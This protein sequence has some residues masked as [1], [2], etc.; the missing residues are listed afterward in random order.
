[1]LY[2][3]RAG[4]PIRPFVGGGVGSVWWRGEAFCDWRQV[5]CQLVLPDDAPG[6]LRAREW[7]ASFAGGL[8]VDGWRGVIVRGGLRDTVVPST[9]WRRSDDG[10][11][12]RAVRGQLPEFFLNIGYRW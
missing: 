9:M 5:D 7:V 8:A 6:V 11:R 12:R 1:M 10:A 4:R 2:H 3:F